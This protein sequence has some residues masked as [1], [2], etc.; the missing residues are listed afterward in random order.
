[1][2][3]YSEWTSKKW[4][5]TMSTDPSIA[6]GNTLQFEGNGSSKDASNRL[7]NVSTGGIVW[8]DQFSYDSGA[9]Q[10]KDVKRG[11][12]ELVIQRV[13][14]SGAPGSHDTLTCEL[15]PTPIIHSSGTGSACW[16]ANDG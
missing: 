12:M 13:K 4:L 15:A 3:T 2:A 8:T 16:T 10:V 5:V 14:G 6:P 11:T 1:M 9:D 7:K